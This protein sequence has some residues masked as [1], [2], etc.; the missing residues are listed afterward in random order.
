MDRDGRV[1][2]VW[3]ASLYERLNNLLEESGFDAFVEERRRKGTVSAR[4]QFVP[5]MLSR[6][7]RKRWN[8]TAPLV[9]K[10][11]T[12]TRVRYG[13]DL[14]PHGYRC[15]S[16]RTSLIDSQPIPDRLSSM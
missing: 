9:K 15:S 11:S 13:I 7:I 5:M 10:R 8:Q 4:F 14:E 3:G 16:D 1:A 12:G 6:G 2:A